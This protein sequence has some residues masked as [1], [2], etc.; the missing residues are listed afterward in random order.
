MAGI[1]NSLTAFSFFGSVRTP[2]QTLCTQLRKEALLWLEPQPSFPEVIQHLP[3]IPIVFLK[4]LLRH[5]DVIKIDQATFPD[6]PGQHILHQT[7]EGGRRTVAS[8]LEVVRPYC[9]VLRTTPT[10]A[11]SL[12]KFPHKCGTAMAVPAL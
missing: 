9:V 12:V 5:Q 6:Q 2:L 11:Y 1:G 4:S 10:F 7:L 3:E 8:S